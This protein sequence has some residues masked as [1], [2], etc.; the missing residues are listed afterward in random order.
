MIALAFQAST[1]AQY[2]FLGDVPS[3]DQLVV[4]TSK[5]PDGSIIYFGDYFST[6]KDYT[7]VLSVLKH[8]HSIKMFDPNIRAAVGPLFLE[9]VD[10][11]DILRL[12]S[13]DC[14]AVLAKLSIKT[15]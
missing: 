7:D 11:C 10:V 14:N 4:V 2:Q 13:D 12:S 1:S 15:E 6:S 3:C 9:C 8:K 5:I